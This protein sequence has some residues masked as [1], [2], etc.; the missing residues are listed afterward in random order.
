MEPTAE[1]RRFK[2]VAV[3]SIVGMV[4]LLAPAVASAPCAEPQSVNTVGSSSASDCTAS[5][6]MAGLPA[7]ASVEGDPTFGLPCKGRGECFTSVY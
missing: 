1:S 5:R 2:I 7:P 6:L 3:L 4:C